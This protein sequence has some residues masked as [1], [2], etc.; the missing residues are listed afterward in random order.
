Q[1][2]DPLPANW[3]PGDHGADGLYI[4]IAAGRDDLP[5]AALQRTGLDQVCLRLRAG[6]QTSQAAGKI[7][8]ARGP[9]NRIQPF[10]RAL[11]GLNNPKSARRFPARQ[12]TLLSNR[13]I[14]LVRLAA[15]MA[16]Q[17]DCYTY[18]KHRA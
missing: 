4:R 13:A 14:S 16:Q 11:L 3:I 7:P 18:L 6:D 12:M 10:G 5:R 9:I 15:R 8:V 1:Q 2:P 17:L